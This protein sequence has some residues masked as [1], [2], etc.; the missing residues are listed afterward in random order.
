MK[1]MGFINIVRI[2]RKQ[3]KW[4]PCIIILKYVENVKKMKPKKNHQNNLVYSSVVSRNKIV[5]I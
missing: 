5:A 4:P 3:V 1:R 2:P